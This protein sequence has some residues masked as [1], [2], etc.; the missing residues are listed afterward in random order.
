MSKIPGFLIAAPKSNSGKTLI[1]C[2]LLK[3]LKKRGKSVTAFKCGPDFIDPM[4]HRR[5]MG[6]PS[7][8]LDT[9]F[10]E[11][12]VTRALFAEGAS[13]GEI[14]VGEGVMGLFDGMGGSEERGSSYDLARTLGMSIVLII[15][16][17]GL[18]RSILPIVRGF[19]DYDTENLIKGIIL[20]RVGESQFK[21]LKELVES[22]L[23]ISVFGYFP[24]TKA[25]EIKSRHLGLITPGEVTDFNELTEKGSAVAEECIDISALEKLETKTDYS[26]AGLLEGLLKDYYSEEFKGVKVGVAMD[27]AFCFYY[28]DNLELIKKMGAEIL[29]FSPIKDT[30]LPENVDAL[31]FPGGYPELFAFELSTNTALMQ[32]I[33]IKIANGIPVIAECGGYMYLTESIEE[34]SGN[35]YPMTDIIETKTRYEGRSSRFG[36][37]TVREN[38]EGTFLG[39]DEIRG[40]E[41]HYFNSEDNGDDCLAVKP[42]GNKKW[43]CVHADKTKWLGYPHL[44]YYSCPAYAYNFLKA[45]KKYHG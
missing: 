39:G 24:E 43:L 16:A 28:E 2:A 21:L 31:I 42:V 38:V 20:N 33:Q 36:Y 8:N 44:Y 4:F 30:T 25:F 23:K 35:I 14:T 6:V 1:T 37:I 18:S 7:K 22:E 40:H 3:A 12:E 34:K 17:K 15:D 13:L 11:S 29:P 41:F 45:A 19:L 27:D 26:E 9:F 10:T 5:V 32:D